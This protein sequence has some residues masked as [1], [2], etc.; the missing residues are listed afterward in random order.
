MGSGDI[1]FVFGLAVA[2]CIVGGLLHVSWHGIK[3]LLTPQGIIYVLLGCLGSVVWG[4]FIPP[5]DTDIGSILG[6]TILGIV[7]AFSVVLLAGWY[8][9]EKFMPYADEAVERQ[10]LEDM[11]AAFKEAFWEAVDRMGTKLAARWGEYGRVFISYRRDDG[12]AQARMIA[13]QLE[14]AFGPELVFLDVDKIRPGADFIK[15]IKDEVAKCDV[16][17]VLIGRNWL[18]RNKAGQRLFDNPNDVVRLEVAAALQRQICVIPIL[19]DG[20]PMP[21]EDQLPADLQGL[22]RRNALPLRHD[23]FKADMKKLV[24]ELKTIKSS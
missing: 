6:A 12:Y 23:S 2:G 8:L 24:R 15:V 19:F 13:D 21:T 9:I 22:R 17:L 18:G 7:G 1:L 5:Y 20:A 16:L 10:K 4:R 3:K 14:N 11:K